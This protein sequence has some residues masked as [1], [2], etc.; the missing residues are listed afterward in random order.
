[1]HCLLSGAAPDDAVFEFDDNAQITAEQLLLLP[2]L[3]LMLLLWFLLL[4]LVLAS[5][6]VK[7]ATRIKAKM[8]QRPKT[9]AKHTRHKKH[10]QQHECQINRKQQKNYNKK[11]KQHILTSLPLSLSLPSPLSPLHSLLPPSTHTNVTS[12][13]R[14]LGSQTVPSCWQATVASLLRS[15]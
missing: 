14:W 12:L 9:Q 3:L 2:L 5:S 4:L 6:A 7:H 15:C 8:L 13:V 11:R 1:M 10:E